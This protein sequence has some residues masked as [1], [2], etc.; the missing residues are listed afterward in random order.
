MHQSVGA[1]FGGVVDVLAGERQIEALTGRETERGART[2]DIL[3]TLR[4]YFAVSTAVARARRNGE[5]IV[6][7]AS[8]RH[9][10]RQRVGIAGRSGA[11]GCE[12]VTIAGELREAAG[13]VVDGLVAIAL[14]RHA[15]DAGEHGV[16]ELE[17]VT[18][19]DVDAVEVAVGHRDV[20]GVIALRRFADVTDR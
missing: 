11:V 15:A 12:P 4:A 1:R 7:R 9:G 20:A 16:R 5:R 18:G 14:L 13:E 17:V 19:A 6:R 10:V 3:A 2:G 8:R